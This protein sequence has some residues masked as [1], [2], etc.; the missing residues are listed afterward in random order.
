MVRRRSVPRRNRI[1]VAAEG[2]GERALAR[3]LGRLCDEQGLHVHLDVVVAGGGDTRSVVEFAV[4]RRRR[5]ID[6]MGRDNGALVFLD[7]DRLGRDRASGRD[8]DRVIGRELLQLVFLA[9]N[10]EGLLLRL[11]SGREAQFV[12]PDDAERLLQQM[13]PEYRKPMSARA[14]ERRF[15]LLDL[16]RAAAYDPQLRDALTL[17][18]LTRGI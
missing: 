5:H 10:L 9:P 14:L 4:D 17:L 3:W 18:G 15:N 13:W 12:V 6:S 7:A 11:H 2:F 8:P 1:F 16:E